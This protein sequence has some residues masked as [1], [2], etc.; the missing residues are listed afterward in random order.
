MFHEMS[1]L[2]QPATYGFALSLRV[3]LKRWQIGNPGGTNFQS[4]FGNSEVTLCSSFS[5]GPLEQHLGVS[6]VRT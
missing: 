3:R 2:P 6:V 1:P 4:L 5:N